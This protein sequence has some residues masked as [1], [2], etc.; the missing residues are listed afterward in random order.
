MISAEWI[1]SLDSVFLHI[2]RWAVGAVS[3][4]INTYGNNTQ[5]ADQHNTPKFTLCWS[6]SKHRGMKKANQRTSE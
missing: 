2:P 4:K 5:R 3:W 1:F 6:V